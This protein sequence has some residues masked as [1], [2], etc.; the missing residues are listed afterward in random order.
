MSQSFSTYLVCDDPERTKFWKETLG[1]DVVPVTSPIPQ[2]VDIEGH[3]IEKVF[4]LDVSALTPEQKSNLINGLAVKFGLSFESV[5]K[6]FSSNGCPVL[7]K[8]TTVFSN[9]LWFLD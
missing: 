9:R 5:Q 4:M 6:D 1:F 7:A 8:D 2:I 3:G